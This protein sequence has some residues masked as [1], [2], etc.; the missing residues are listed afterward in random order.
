M[1]CCCCFVWLDCF[2]FLSLQGDIIR[3]CEQRCDKET[4]AEAGSP[5]R[6]L[7]TNPSQQAKVV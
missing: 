2:G 4:R 6:R 7:L 5:L 3:D 1:H